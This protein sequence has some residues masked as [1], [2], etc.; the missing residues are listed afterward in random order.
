MPRDL[1]YPTGTPDALEIARQV[2]FVNHFYAL[3]NVSIETRGKIVTV[4]VRKAKGG[5]ATT[6]TVKRYINNDYSDGRIR[7]RDL[8]IFTTGRMRGTGMLVTDYVDDAKSQTYAA[9]LPALRKVRRFAQPAH[10]DLWGGTDFT[11]G[12]VTLR[13]P[14]HETHELLG[15]QPF[16][17]CL[18]VISIPDDE[19][20]WFMKTLPTQPVCT[21]KGT[22]VYL[23]KSTTRFSN[24]WYDHRISYVDTQTFADYRTEY[25][26]NGEKIKIIDR[27][28][29][30]LS[31]PDPRGLA[32]KFWYGQNLKTGHETMAMVPSEVFKFNTRKRASL[33]S[34]ETL[35]HLKR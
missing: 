35:S 1:P 10:E 22:P 18:Q 28:W 9:W 2:Y 13:K 14:F 8:A 11:F 31:L 4:I 17:D 3:R 23:L 30:S 7:S 27:D 29:S 34:E 21:H 6:N 19:K 20:T 33:W 32:W 26:K 12:D 15:T 25:F 5:R 16:P 24:W